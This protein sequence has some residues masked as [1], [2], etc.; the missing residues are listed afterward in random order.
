MT[1]SINFNGTLLSQNEL[2]LSAENRA[3]RYGDGIFETLKVINGKILFLDLHFERLRTGVERLKIQM[4]ENFSASFFEKE[5]QKVTLFSGNFRVRFTIF[6]ADGGF[7]EPTNYEGK[8]VVEA[9]A[10]SDILYPN[11]EKGLKVAVSNEIYV[12]N[13]YFSGIKSINSLPY[14]MASI[15]KKELAFDDLLLKNAAGNIAEAT[16][17]NIFFIKNNKIVTPPISEGCI[18]GVMRKIILELSKELEFDI[19][20]APVPVAD[21]YHYDE[22]ILTNVI[23]GI[24]WVEFVEE[25]V[26]QK[27]KINQFTERLNNIVTL[28]IN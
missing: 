4:P 23:Q 17:S 28:K 5:I 9:F 7:Y 25:K 24:R 27:N 14:V 8:F 22:I 6:R 12:Q 26:F 15:Q 19:A 2:F 21:I 10:I 20:V 13:S 1:L 16:H 11:Y 3:Y 18:D